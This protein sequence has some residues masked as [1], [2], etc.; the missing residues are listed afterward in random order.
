MAQKITLVIIDPQY[1]F[2]DNEDACLPVKGGNAD[3]RRVADLVR[4]A[5]HLF[6][7]IVVTMD[8]HR[9]IDIAHPGFWRDQNGKMPIPFS[10]PG[11]AP[12]IISS[13][14]VKNGIWVPN[15]ETARPGALGGL[16][17]RE[18]A[19]QYTKAL[20]TNGQYALIIWPEHCL[21]GTPGHAIQADLASA[22]QDWERREFA[23][24]TYVTKGTNT[25]T[26]HYGALMAEVPLASDPATGLNGLLLGQFQGSKRVLFC[27][28][29][30]DFCLRTTY[31]QVADNLTQQEVEQIEILTDATSP[32]ISNDW[33]ADARARGTKL[34]K[35]TDF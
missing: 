19:Y 24:V 3:M 33:L 27:G 4:R 22:L 2:M 23:N 16:T 17:L 1:D 7:E 11:G 35:T 31:M 12:L 29:A 20:E 6:S 8:S 34:S 13:D 21:I 28:E 26:E 18:Y 32:I 15:M 9:V 5:G 25:F 14:D 10:G 30:S